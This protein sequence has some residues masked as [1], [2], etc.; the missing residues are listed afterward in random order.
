MIQVDS[1]LSNLDMRLIEK[2]TVIKGISGKIG[3]KEFRIGKA[4]ELLINSNTSIAVIADI[5]GFSNL[6]NFNRQFKKITN[7]SP[8]Q[9]L[10]RHL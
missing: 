5:V 8:S 6:S 4:C 2:D 10:K 7:L 1:S 9:Y 3:D